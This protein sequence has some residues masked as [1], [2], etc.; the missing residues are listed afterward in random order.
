[1]LRPI[2][3][4]VEWEP[5]CVECF[6][7]SSFDETDLEV[8][9]IWSSMECD[10]PVYCTQCGGLISVLL[11]QDGLDYVWDWLVDFIENGHGNREVIAPVFRQYLYPMFDNAIQLRK[12]Q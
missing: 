3:Y 9:P 2:G 7:A 1:M 12:D 6:T 8:D 5:H 11:T 10:C 4:F